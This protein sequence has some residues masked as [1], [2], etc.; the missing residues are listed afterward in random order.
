MIGQTVIN[1]TALFTRDGEP[2]AVGTL[3]VV[4]GT[5]KGGQILQVQFGERIVLTTP[6]RVMP[7]TLPE[8][9]VTLSD[10][11]ISLVAHLSA[12]VEA[13]RAELAERTPRLAPPRPDF[14]WRTPKTNDR[15][16]NGN[17]RQ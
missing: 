5:L 15:S 8:T 10:D 17:G 16:R 11:L 6:A 3:G 13:L 7:V 1:T 4:C 9:G 14:S 12:E 2:I